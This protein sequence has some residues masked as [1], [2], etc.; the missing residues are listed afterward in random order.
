MINWTVSQMKKRPFDD[1]GKMRFGW[2]CP[3]CKRNHPKGEKCEKETV[4]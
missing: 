4:E 1:W 2:F 3:L